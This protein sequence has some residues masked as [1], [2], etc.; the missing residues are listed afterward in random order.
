MSIHGVDTVSLGS[1]NGIVTAALKIRE[2]PG[3]SAQ[4]ITWQCDMPEGEPVKSIE[5]G[6]QLTV[7]ARTKEKNKVGKWNNYWYYV[8]YNPDCED[9]GSIT[10]WVFGEFVKIK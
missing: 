9:S 1:K 7:F 6:K 8:M 10:G 2:S 3:T 4:E 5:K